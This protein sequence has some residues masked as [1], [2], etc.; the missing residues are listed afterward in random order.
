MRVRAR[1]S[2][3]L[4]DGGQDT[5]TKDFVAALPSAVKDQA[6]RDARSV[7]RRSCELGEL[8]VLHRPIGPWNTQHWRPA[9]APS[10]GA[11][12]WRIEGDTLLI[13]V[14][15]A[16]AR[17]GQIA[18]RCSGAGPSGTPG[19]LRLTRTRGTRTRGTRTRGTRVADVADTL[20]DAAA[21]RRSSKA[22][23]GSTWG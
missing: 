12:H 5:S 2:D 9:L 21:R 11:Q 14:C 7:W 8:P 20:P 10:T 6:L 19:L 4:P 16:D 1:D 22:S 3:V 17:V 13:P 23:W 15:H 18:L